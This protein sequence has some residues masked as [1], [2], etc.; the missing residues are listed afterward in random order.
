MEKKQKHYAPEN[1]KMW[2]Q[3][4]LCWSW[5]SLL[6]LRLYMK[7]N[8]GEFKR[9][10]NVIFGNFRDSEI[11]SFGK[12]GTLKLLKLSKTKIQKL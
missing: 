1:F 10:K 6:P 8:F 3:A 11:W 4:W 7:S 2:S 9:S 12:F 5:I